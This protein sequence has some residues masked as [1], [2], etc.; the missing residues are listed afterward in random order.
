MDKSGLNP[1][2][3]FPNGDMTEDIPEAL[4]EISDYRKPSP[5]NW[6]WLLAGGFASIGLIALAVFFLVP[7]KSSP[8]STD[9][10]TP[11]TTET[12][13]A[14]ETSV[15]GE[16]VTAVGETPQ[17]DNI[18]GHKAY[19]EAAAGDLER[20]YNGS[21]IRMRPAAAQKLREMVAA[22]RASGI[23]ISIIS[24]YRSIEEQK[25]LFFEIKEQR[26]QDTSVRAKV[27]APPGYSEH[28]TGYAVD[29]GDGNAP[30]TNLSQSFEQTRAFAWMQQ[31]AA[32]YSFELSFPR[33][34]PQ[35]ISY[36]PWHWRY[37]GDT[38]SLETFYKNR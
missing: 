15:D 13:S 19:Q 6:L 30:G 17:E 4:R 37:V 21:A 12:T 18:L 36:E 14:A 10:K 35:G 28:H 1:K 5:N 7:G 32:R 29:I 20:I 11:S 24:G 3:Q 26:S 25:Y 9:V 31:N 38:D 23:N 34:N 33:D 22:A 8:D 27:S 2:Q 16:E